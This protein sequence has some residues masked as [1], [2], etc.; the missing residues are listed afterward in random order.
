MEAVQ[1][2]YKTALA[3][4]L[5]LEE[6]LKISDNLNDNKQQVFLIESQLQ[7][8]LVAAKKF[9]GLEISNLEFKMNDLQL[10]LNSKQ[11]Q[12]QASISMIKKLLSDTSTFNQDIKSKEMRRSLWNWHVHFLSRK[13]ELYLLDWDAYLSVSKDAVATCLKNNSSL[14]ASTFLLLRAQ[15]AMVLYRSDLVEPILIQ[16]SEF[17]STAASSPSIN[18]VALNYVKRFYYILQTMFLVCSGKMNDALPVLSTLHALLDADQSFADQDDLT[19]MNVDLI[20]DT[21]VAQ[22][23]TDKQYE[24]GLI[25]KQKKL[26]YLVSYLMSG[27]VHKSQDTSKALLFLNEGLSAIDAESISSSKDRDKSQ[28]LLLL[29][30]HIQLQLIEIYMNSSQLSLAAQTLKDVTLKSMDH[31]ILFA[32]LESRIQFDWACLFHCLGDV[33]RAYSMYLNLVHASSN[34]AV[35]PSLVWMAR[36]NAYLI[37]LSCEKLDH[38]ALLQ[39]KSEFVADDLYQSIVTSLVNASTNMAKSQ[40]KASKQELLAAFKMTTHA[41][42]ALLSAISLQMVAD[43]FWD[44]NYRQA[45]TMTTKSLALAKKTRSLPVVVQSLEKLGVAQA[46]HQ[47]EGD[48]HAISSEASEA[49]SQ[50]DNEIKEALL[51]LQ[52]CI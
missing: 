17:I 46:L 44:T 13:L 45:I 39:I 29:Q 34:T 3:Q 31:H 7:K 27:I 51:V 28:Q 15:N 43:L 5:G 4:L 30:V 48:E 16:I 19:M 10:I 50:L 49:R 40:I 33:E 42:D 37:D 6:N 47:D 22:T 12:K 24:D 20:E 41:Q 23:E 11:G 9:T 26:P 21:P 8:G 2:H 25:W 1:H 32:S 35:E 38:D 52:D 14:Q 36:V 18:K